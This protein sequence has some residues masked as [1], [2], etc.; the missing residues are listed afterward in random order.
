MGVP[1]WKTASSRSFIVQT[2]KSSLEVMAVAIQGTRLALLVEHER[3]AEYVCGEQPVAAAVTPGRHRA[4]HPA[5]GCH[6]LSVVQVHACRNRPGPWPG[7]THDRGRRDVCGPGVAG[8]AAGCGGSGVSAGLG[9]LGS[10][11][12]GGRSRGRR[13]FGRTRGCL[14]RRRVRRLATAAS[15]GEDDDGRDGRQQQE[16]RSRDGSHRSSPSCPH[17]ETCLRRLGGG[18][19]RPLRRLHTAR[20][21]V[22]P[23]TSPAPA[24]AATSGPVGSNLLL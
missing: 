22:R 8:L 1:S 16:H 12:L 24:S 6:D 17:Q 15:G 2:V 10:L 13:W 23:C 7:M 9:L 3:C 18:R 20:R 21:Q 4:A 5:D 19:H 11:R 14:R